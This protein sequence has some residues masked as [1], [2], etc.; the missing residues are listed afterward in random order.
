M[1]DMPRDDGRLGRRNM[2]LAIAAGAIAAAAMIVYG[3]PGLDPGLWNEVSVVSGLRPPRTIFPGFWRLGAALL[4]RFLDL[5]T[6]TV[7]LRWL[8]AVVGGCCVSVFCL[9]VRQILALV[10]HTS[11]PYAVW[12]RQIAPL[13]AFLGAL[14]FGVSD[15][16]WR[17][18]RVFSP[19]LMRLGL[20]MLAVHWILRWFAHGGRWRILSAFALMGVMAAETPF[21]FLLPLLFVV[22]YAAVWHCVMDGMI[23]KPD[24]L[25][26]PVEL[27]KWRMF[28]VFLGALAAAVWLNTL[29]FVHFGGIEANGWSTND[30]YFRY[31][32]GYWRMLTGAATLMGWALGLGVCVLP[33]LVALTMFPR[34][35]RDD[36]PMAFNYGVMLFFVGVLAAMQC[37]AFPSARFWTYSTDT[38]MVE[39]GFLLAFFVACA[40]TSFALV[41][42]A[43]AFECQRKYLT[44]DAE[45]DEP[46]QRVAEKPG[47]MLRGVAPALSCC[48]AAL[49]LCHLRKPVETEMQSI[50]D[51]AVAETVE[52]CDGAKWIF[53]D[54]RLDA[55]VELAAAA[56]GVSLTTLDMMSGATEWERTVRV[57]GFKERTDDYEAA[58]KGTPTLLRIWAG[59]KTNGM[60]GVAI[61]LGFEFWKRE[62]RPL[63]KASGMVARE[64]GMTDEA[65]EKGVAR[66]KEL[67]RRILD[68]AP[69]VESASPSPALASAFSAVAWRLSRFARLR[70]DRGLAD[71]LDLSNSALKKMLSVIEYERTRTFM[72]L[73]PREG[74]QLAL[75]RAD[76]AEARRYAT[77][78]LH[79]DEDDAEANFA[80]GMQA[81]IAKDLSTAELYLKRCLKRRP[82]EPAVLNNLSIICRKQRRWKE[83]EDYA[84]RAMEVLPD[85]PEV[86][87]TLSDVLKKAP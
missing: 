43:F 77:V 69:Q 71:E 68:V 16:L 63:P 26:E 39:S 22:S 75:K 76:F 13:F 44:A 40:M 24:G 66:A 31:A 12:Y 10:I 52:E 58:E 85:S 46:G 45:Q 8:G 73:T 37:G 30:I 84:R 70:E 21:A 7:V 36:Q 53:T 81:L 35:V 32:G 64:V 74:L 80:M 59:E 20:L 83:S 14:L 28:F 4:F 23:Q 47:R 61:Q 54:G 65:A 18:C 87:Q 38:V 55:G 2:L 3:V 29:G 9:I 51:D 34:S 72:Q 60:D 62:R 6:A 56:K 15:P 19:E 67:S 82:K 11:R 42:A 1:R 78:V 27:P 49:A 79:N 17:I 5:G 25:P 41:G 86:R 48:L 57:R 33:L 50:V